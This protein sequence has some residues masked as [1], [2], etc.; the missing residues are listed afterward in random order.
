MECIV[1]GGEV[2]DERF[3]YVFPEK[4]GGFKALYD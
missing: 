2:I 1:E 4:P 3:Q